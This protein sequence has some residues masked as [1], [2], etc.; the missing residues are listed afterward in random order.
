MDG[1]M[2]HTELQVNIATIKLISHWF[3][4]E[5][6]WWYLLWTIIW[7][8]L[9]HSHCEKKRNERVHFNKPNMTDM[10]TT[11]ELMVLWKVIQIKAT[12]HSSVSR[13]MLKNTFLT[14]VH[15]KG[16]SHRVT[17]A[18]SLQ[19]LLF[20]KSLTWRQISLSCIVFMWKVLQGV[21]W[22]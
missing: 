18:L 5:T 1:W 19:S 20:W 6:L 13:I 2:K 10:E 22:L 21:F 11:T 15:W 16:Y 4:S 9:R 3:T 12:F 14:E 7:F 17:A 8:N